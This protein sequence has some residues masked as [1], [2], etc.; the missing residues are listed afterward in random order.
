[1]SIKGIHRKER[2]EGGRASTPWFFPLAA[3]TLSAAVGL[4][5]AEIV[6]QIW[7]HAP[8]FHYIWP[9]SRTMIYEPAEGTLTG[10]SGTSRYITNAWG[11]RGGEFSED[12]DYRILAIGGSTTEGIYLDETENWPY[13][14]EKGINHKTGTYRV[15][16]GNIGKSAL[17]TRDH[18]YTLKTLLDECPRVDALI[19]MTGVN[20][21]SA[22][23]CLDDPSKV[24]L[25]L[26]SEEDLPDRSYYDAP[27]ITEHTPLYKRTGL[28]KLAKRVELAA[29]L[30][31]PDEKLDGMLTGRIISD[32]REHRRRAASI[33]ETLPDLTEALSL[34]ARELNELVDAALA[35]QVKPLLVTHPVLWREDLPEDLKDLLWL[36]GIGDF[37]NEWGKEYYS[38]AALAEAMDRYNGTLL[39]VCG[40]R[41]LDCLDLAALIPQDGGHFFDDCHFS[42]RGACAVAEALTRFVTGLRP[43][44]EWVRASGQTG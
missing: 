36:G 44:S 42:E 14:L 27:E 11:I 34:Y 32:W 10:I 39:K 17:N 5:L 31:F 13:L 22:A 37:E 28:W 16:V 3:A 15:W 18:V 38:A 43:V 25:Q 1:M 26:G 29:Q 33:R 19:V 20:D 6:L 12:Q 41:G 30:A 35:Q 9:P 2:A 7:F 23:L 4:L 21:L 40:D 24:A 8:P